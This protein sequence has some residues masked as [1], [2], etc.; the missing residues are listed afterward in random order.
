MGLLIDLRLRDPS[1]SSEIAHQAAT[2]DSQTLTLCGI[3]D[4]LTDHRAG[5][6][7]LLAV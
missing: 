3:F 5:G 7:A 2:G 4:S 1:V 6:K